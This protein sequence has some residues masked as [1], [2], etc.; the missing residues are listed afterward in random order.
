MREFAVVAPCE[1]EHE[2][3]WRL[4]FD[5]DI[6]QKL[7]QLDNLALTRLRPDNQTECGEV[8]RMAECTMNQGEQF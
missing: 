1:L 5:Y 6:Q 7:K 2:V 4:M 8:Q 3:L